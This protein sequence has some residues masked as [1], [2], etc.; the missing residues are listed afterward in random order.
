MKKVCAFMLVLILF[1]SGCSVESPRIL[2]QTPSYD[3]VESKE[4]IV[5]QFKELY[6][7]SASIGQISATIDFSSVAEMKKAFVEGS[8]DSSQISLVQSYA[9]EDC[10]IE[11]LPSVLYDFVLPE[12]L[13][14]SSV[15]WEGENYGCSFGGVDGTLSGHFQ[16]FSS[17]ERYEKRY[18]HSYDIIFQ[19]E[20][21]TIVSQ[22]QIA[23]RNATEVHYKTSVA[24][25]K[26]ILYEMKLSGGVAFVMEHYLLSEGAAGTSSSM[27]PRSVEVFF[28]CDSVYYRVYLYDLKQRPNIDFLQAFGL[29][30]Y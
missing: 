22:E 30:E 28:E 26:S 13:I 24:L 20:N 21:V 18:L 6:E 25:S 7:G 14:V 29:A 17:K 1:L 23:D 8:L 16:M 2:L 15:A 10:S 11:V 5:Y 3:V 12:G 19:N 27:V 4:G 9:G